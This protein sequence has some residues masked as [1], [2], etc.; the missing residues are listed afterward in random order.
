LGTSFDSIY[1]EFI[2]DQDSLDRQLQLI[3][4]LFD[5]S[6]EIIHNAVFNI[7][8]AFNLKMKDSQRIQLDK[9]YIHN[10]LTGDSNSW[11]DREDPIYPWSYSFFSALQGKK[12]LNFDK[13][14]ENCYY[15]CDLVYAD[16]EG[17]LYFGMW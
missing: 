4:L 15:I 6:R 1:L 10:I 12:F 8:R 17:N 9:I 14:P 5:Q 7:A 3:Q 13:L 11:E 2:E 16:G